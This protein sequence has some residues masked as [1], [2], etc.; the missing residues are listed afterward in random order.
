MQHC[1]GDYGFFLVQDNTIKTKKLG[2]CIKNFF[3]PLPFL[4]LLNII[5]EI[6]LPI[7]LSFRLLATC[8]GAL[9]LCWHFTTLLPCRYLLSEMSILVFSP[10]LESLFLLCSR[11]PYQY[12][13]VMGLR[14]EG[15]S[16]LVKGGGEKRE[17]FWYTF[18]VYWEIFWIAYADLSCRPDDPQVK[19][20]LQNIPLKGWWKCLFK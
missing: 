12:S 19:V 5:S 1:F 18:F 13:I 7:S 15:H 20:F 6:A 14:F 17:F 2:T 3:E 16:F 9:L 10:E 8:Q 11:W 4:F